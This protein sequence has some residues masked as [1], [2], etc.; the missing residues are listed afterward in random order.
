[1]S[2]SCQ[3]VRSLN[4]PNGVPGWDALQ[5]SGSGRVLK[6][7]MGDGQFNYVLNPNADRKPGTTILVSTTSWPVTIQGGS[8]GVFQ[9]DQVGQLGTFSGWYESYATGSKVRGGTYSPLVA[10]ATHFIY[11][12]PLDDAGNPDYYVYIDTIDP[13]RGVHPYTR[14]KAIGS[15]KTPPQ[16]ASVNATSRPIMDLATRIK[17]LEGA[18]RVGRPSGSKS[19]DYRLAD[20]VARFYALEQWANSAGH[21]GTPPALGSNTTY[22]ETDFIVNGDA[23]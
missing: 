7:L 20:L 15:F 4:G 19:Q 21:F 1:M 11:W 3:T 8:G 18:L 16:P 2:L 6:V 5:I 23:A 17:E 14:D 10:D 13:E 22:T 9:L 12:S